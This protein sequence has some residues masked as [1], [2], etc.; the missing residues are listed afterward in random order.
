MSKLFRNTVAATAV[1]LVAGSMSF[2][3]SSGEALYKAKS[4]MCHGEKGLADSGAAKAMKR[5]ACYRS[6][7]EEAE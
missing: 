1:L 7:C 4:Q 3:Q 2:A 5:E 6:R